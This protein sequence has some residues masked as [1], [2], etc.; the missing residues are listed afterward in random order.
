MAWG[1]SLRA[2]WRLP[3]V[4]SRPTAM[5]SRACSSLELSI[6]EPPAPRQRANLFDLLARR[7][8]YGVGCKV[9]RTLWEKN[10][11]EPALH[12]W[13]ITR[14]KDFKIKSFNGSSFQRGKAYGIKIWKGVP[15]GRETRVT[16]GHK[17]EWVLLNSP[18]MDADEDVEES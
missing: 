8:K 10:G 17:R 3:A 1:L 12:H 15:V 9:Y 5:A 14:T 6:L 7:P 18:E 2:A 13:Q 16:S 4:L 11:Y